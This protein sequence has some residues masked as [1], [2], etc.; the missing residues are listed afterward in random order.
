MKMHPDG[1][2]CSPETAQ[3]LGAYILDVTL[4]LRRIFTATLRTTPPRIVSQNLIEEQLQIY[5]DSD[6]AR[7]HRRVRGMN[8]ATGF[9]RRLAALIQESLRE[10]WGEADAN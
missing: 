1:L 4:V 9:E 2:Q 5:K 8:T 6:L 7:N 10:I 3:Y